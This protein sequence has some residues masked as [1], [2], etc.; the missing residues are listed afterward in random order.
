M[1]EIGVA[2]IRMRDADLRIAA[3]GYKAQVNQVIFT[4]EPTLLWSETY[5]DSDRPLLLPDRTRW[6]VQIGFVQ[7]LT[8]PGSL[9]TYLIEHAAQQRVLTFTIPGVVV[10]ATVL[11]IPAGFGGVMG[12]T[13]VATATLPLYG[14]PDLTPGA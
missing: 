12:Q 2:P 4:P 5:T 14:A 10:A 9:S 1:P 3:D 13:P 11:I 7:D 8:T 6:T